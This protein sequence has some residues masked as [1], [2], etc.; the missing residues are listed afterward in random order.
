MNFEIESIKKFR[1]QIS[2][3]EVSPKRNQKV[4]IESW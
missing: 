2:H 4:L 3:K 1:T